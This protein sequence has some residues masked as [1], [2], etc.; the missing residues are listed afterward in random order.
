[1]I[2]MLIKI[3]G[4][5]GIL[6]CIIM[7]SLNS[8]AALIIISRFILSYYYFL[9]TTVRIRIMFNISFG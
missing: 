3:F 8:Y 6:A 7:S 1:M 4:L 5:L 9:P 2:M